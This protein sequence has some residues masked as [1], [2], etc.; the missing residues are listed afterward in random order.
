[1]KKFEDHK[2]WR[3]V[4]RMVIMKKKKLTHQVSKKNKTSSKMTMERGLLT[5]RQGS[6]ISCANSTNPAGDERART[7]AWAISP[8]YIGHTM[9][10]AERQAALSRGAWTTSTSDNAALKRL[11]VR[12]LN[13]GHPRDKRVY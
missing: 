9:V 8:P 6:A 2:K 12:E 1:M 13:P 4:K 3:W 10:G 11:S 5:T 7:A